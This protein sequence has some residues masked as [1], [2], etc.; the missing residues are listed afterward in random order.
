MSPS[1]VG[2]CIR[3]SSLSLS[4][5]PSWRGTLRLHHTPGRREAVSLC[6]LVMLQQRYS[7][8]SKCWGRQKWWRGVGSNLHGFGIERFEVHILSFGWDVKTLIPSSGFNLKAWLWLASLPLEKQMQ[9]VQLWFSCSVMSNS[10]Q[11][12]G[13]QHTR[14]LKGCCWP[15]KRRQDSWPLEKKNQSGARD[16]AWSLRAFV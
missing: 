5:C 15:M 8:P 16:T 7:Q 2:T 14:L 11:P 13:L 10:F 3:M 1:F 12:H 4:S 9:L 6:S